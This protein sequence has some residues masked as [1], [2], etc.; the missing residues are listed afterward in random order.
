MTHYFFWKN[1]SIGNQFLYI[2]L[3]I[4]LF[5][6]LGLSAYLF[7]VGNGNVIHWEK[8]GELEVVDV[9][10]DRFDKHFFEFTQEADAY[11]LK[12][13]YVASD[14]QVPLYVYYAYLLLLALG[15]VVILAALPALTRIAFLVGMGVM[16]LTWATMGFESLRIFFEVYDKLFAMCFILAFSLLAFF[17]HYIK[18][19][20]PIYLRFLAFSILFV[21]GYYAMMQLT[22]VVY[23]VVHLSV[24]GIAFPIVITVI[25]VLFNGHEVYRFFLFLT[26][27]KS[28]NSG[29]SN[30]QR[31]WF[32]SLVYLAHAIYIYFH[33]AGEIDFDIYYIHPVYLFIVITLLGIWGFKAREVQYEGMFSF[34]AEGAF[35]YLGVAIIAVTAMAYPL[36]TANNPLNEVYEDLI[37]YSQIGF[38]A[39]VLLYVYANFKD[40]LPSGQPVYK[41]Y[42]K[43]LQFDYL[44]KLFTVGLLIGSLLLYKDFF[45]YRQAFAGYFNGLGDLSKLLDDTFSSKQYYNIATGYDARNHRS[46]YALGQLALQA[47]DDAAATIFLEDALMKKPSPFGYSLLGDIQ[48]RRKEYLKA[49]LTYQEG[50]ER[51]EENSELYNNLALILNEREMLPDSVLLYFEEGMQRAG[52]PEVF[53]SNTFTL[54]TKYKIFETLD[55]VYGDQA[56][57]PYIGTASNELAFL[58]AYERTI[59][60]PF[61]YEYISD[62]VINTPQ[63]CYVYNYALN[64]KGAAT[65]TLI[66]LL[67]KLIKVQENFLFIDYLKFALAN[68]YY[69]QGKIGAALEQMQDVYFSSSRTNPDFAHFLGG[70]MLEMGEYEKAADYYHTAYIRGKRGARLNEAV[71]SSELR[72]KSQAIAIW[73]EL[74]NGDSADEVAIAKDMLRFLVK[75]S[76]SVKMVEKASD[77]VKYRY[78]HYNQQLADVDFEQIWNKIGAPK[79][80]SIVVTERVH[81]ALDQQ[82]ETLAGKYMTLAVAGDVSEEVE[83][84]FQQAYLRYVAFQQKFDKDFINKVQEA[85]YNLANQSDKYFYTALY[86]ASVLNEAA[87]VKAFEEA[88]TINPIKEAYYLEWADYYNELQKPNE[89]YEVL[90]KGVEK[91]PASVVLIENYVLQALDLRYNS[92]AESMLEELKLRTSATHYQEFME[93]YRAKLT[94]VEKSFEQW[95][96]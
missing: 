50:I 92:F 18:K 42:Y 71:A 15:S 25:F 33:F 4:T 59:E 67:E 81:F 57:L 5:A 89:A 56:R 58:N 43:P 73:E 61:N 2:L 9:V 32:I 63:L 95:D 11:L 78:L 76:L 90:L 83:P 36:A 84:L 86:E 28:L 27:N 8:Q 24:Y 17:F 51:C 65:P 93:V 21:I 29:R 70:W 1:W 60:V 48:F 22:Q 41:I 40:I 55:S 14:V 23:P 30:A 54:W 47:N 72:D 96:N 69:Y 80:K 3:L 45:P 6:L 35:L 62:T 68:C 49:I 77:V 31:Y 85:E 37:I 94:E 34:N 38:G 64:A 91:N 82:D 12:E 39:G 75:D 20:V 79:V 66:E 74:K 88:T 26:T 53:Q 87:A 16:I 46:Y 7:E 13:K 19:N 44:Y 52:N 10:I